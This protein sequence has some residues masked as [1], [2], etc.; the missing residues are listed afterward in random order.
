MAQAKTT[1]SAKT[2][3]KKAAATKTEVVAKTRIRGCEA[4]ILQKDQKDSQPFA[5]VGYSYRKRDGKYENSSFAMPVDQLQNLG[6]VC[7]ETYLQS[8]SMMKGEERKMV[9]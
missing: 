2:K 7:T 6:T 9:V 8:L 1:S 4:A 5:V 3:T